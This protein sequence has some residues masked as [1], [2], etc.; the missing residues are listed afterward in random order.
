MSWKLLKLN[1]LKKKLFFASLALVVVPMLSVMLILSYSLSKKSEEDFVARVTGEIRQVD[2]VIT[3]L[4]DSAKHNL[5]MMNRHPAMQKLDTS[6]NSYMT[7]PGATD[8]KTVRRG[9]LEQRILD[10]LNLIGKTHPDYIELYLGTKYGGFITS[11]TDKVP[12]GYDPRRRPWYSDALDKKGEAI[13]S[14]AYYSVTT[15]ENVVA[16]V[17]AYTDA[18]GEVQFVGGIDISLKRLTDI[19]NSIRIGKTTGTREPIRITST[20]GMA[21]TAATISSSFAVAKVN[22]SP[23]EIKTSRMAGVLRM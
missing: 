4:L 21:R 12:G 6:I 11:D 3:V 5:E 16:A 13:I 22:G 19:I 20:C 1:G 7:V 8:L 10:H 23:P 9:P 14:K 15:N 2:N 17:K 18:A